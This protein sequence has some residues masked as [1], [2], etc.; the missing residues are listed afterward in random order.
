MNN[1]LTEEVGIDYHFLFENS[2]DGI[3]IHDLDADIIV[4]ANP[5]CLELLDRELEKIL[6]KSPQSFLPINQFD[7]SPTHQMVKRNIQTVLKKKS[8]RF[9]RVHFRKDG[10]KIWLQVNCYLM[11]DA[12]RS[13]MLVVYH[14][15][16]QTKA[17]Q[18]VIE[19]QL[20]CLKEKNEELEKTIES[21]A[22]LENFAFMAAHDLNSPI[23]T[24]VGFSKVLKK[25]LF[26]KSSGDLEEFVNF[27]HDAGENLQALVK[28]LLD[29]SRL[30]SEKIKREPFNLNQMLQRLMLELGSI[31]REEKAVV[32]WDNLP[33]LVIADKVKLRQVFQNLITNAIKFKKKGK[34]PFVEISAQDAGDFW[35]FEI[36]DN[37]IGIE[38]KNFE[39]IFKLFQRLHSKP[40]YQGT[41]LGLAICEKLV[42]QHEGQMWLQSKFGQGTSFY[43]SLPKMV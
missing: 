39:E 37:G 12:N 40:V 32:K 30:K 10:S 21:N 13:L 4:S 6:F 26:N 17:Q 5:K 2:N 35:Q 22:Q 18:A 11:P 36:K 8:N 43:F 25:S 23:N 16:T 38:E 15:I 28:N 29:F 33:E 7:G 42:S 3:L 20:Q 9:Q 14:D 41:G 34:T 31:I 19:N 24:I 27:I 1:F